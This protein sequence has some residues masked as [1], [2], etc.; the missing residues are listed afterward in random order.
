MA[1][2]AA[3]EGDSK[4]DTFENLKKLQNHNSDKLGLCMEG[5]ILVHSTEHFQKTKNKFHPQVHAQD[6]QN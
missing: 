1:G 3:G 2:V 4:H 6:G 5:Q